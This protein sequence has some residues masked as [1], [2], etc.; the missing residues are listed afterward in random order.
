MD[1]RGIP[2]DW[3][4]SITELSGLARLLPAAMFVENSG[5][6]FPREGL[7]IV[8]QPDFAVLVMKDG[9]PL[10][11][12]KRP[13][14]ELSAYVT[15]AEHRAIPPELEPMYRAWITRI[16]QPALAMQGWCAVEAPTRVDFV[17]RLSPHGPFNAGWLR[18]T[19]RCDEHTLESRAR[20]IR[21][22]ARCF[23]KV[24]AVMAQR[25]LDDLELIA[26]RE[27]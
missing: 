15:G 20:R 8:P 25:V 9:E 27:M 23:Q 12:V 3:E 19:M 26:G 4:Y 10:C 5:Q 16:V 2:A 1:F 18:W 17:G 6:A 22:L 24:E 14:V 13:T 11:T 21:W 7:V